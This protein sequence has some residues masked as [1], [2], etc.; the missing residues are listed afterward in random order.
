MAEPLVFSV[1]EGNEKLVFTPQD[2]T[3][4]RTFAKEW[5]VPSN[6]DHILDAS[7]DH[8]NDHGRSRPI[9]VFEMRGFLVCSVEWPSFIE[10]DSEDN[11]LLALIPQKM[12]SQAMNIVGALPGLKH[13]KAGRCIWLA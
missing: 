8:F 5:K 10:V 12:L 3:P 7:M 11:I 6:G 9:S 4:L 2:L 13:D 1:C